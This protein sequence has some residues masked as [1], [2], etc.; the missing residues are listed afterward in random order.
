MWDKPMLLQDIQGGKVKVTFF[1]SLSTWKVSVRK[2]L[3][4]T[5]MTAPLFDTS[6]VNADFFTE[7]DKHN[8][9]IKRNN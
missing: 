2:R 4:D 3:F 9:L 6:S 1:A 8:V 7:E 5:C